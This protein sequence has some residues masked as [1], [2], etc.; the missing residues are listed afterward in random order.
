M[1]HWRRHTF[2]SEIMLKQPIDRKFASLKCWAGKG[3]AK[4]SGGCQGCRHSIS[5]Y[6]V[7][8]MPQIGTLWAFAAWGLGWSAMR[9]DAMCFCSPEL[10]W[11]TDFKHFGLSC[12][13]LYDNADLKCYEPIC[14]VHTWLI[15]KLDILEIL[16]N[17]HHAD[18]MK[19]K[20][21]FSRYSSILCICL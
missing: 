8:K 3:H 7:P 1:R 21:G 17:Q 15:R 20:S 2:E 16:S 18:G 11:A 10:C 19:G 4:V 13:R 6:S 5:I 9:C 12:W 14:L